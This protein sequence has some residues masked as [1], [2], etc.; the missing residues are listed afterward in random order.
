MIIQFLPEDDL[1][2]LKSNLTALEK[3]FANPTNDWLADVFGGK[4]PF[5]DTKFKVEDFELDMSQE[6][7]F[8]S[9]FENVKRVYNRLRF[10]TDS[11]ASDERLW[12]ALCLGPFY[13][14]T[15]YRWGIK[16]NCKASEIEQHFLFASGSRRGVTRN[17]VARLWWI[18]RLTYNEK[19][20]YEL[21]E[22]LCSN[23]DF[24]IQVL[25]RNTSN[26]PTILRAFLRAI[27]DAKKEGCQITQ[28]RVR[29]LAK[30][31]NLLGGTYILDCLT[32][33]Q[34]YN[35][36]YSKAITL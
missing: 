33:E 3:N 24:V 8:H 36:I 25:E 20:E 30:Y 21:T 14:Y 29:D 7:P 2:R 18:G 32:Y 35:K 26:N 5:K 34:I 9:E 1:L 23:A 27:I 16:E 31:L 4:M 28:L 22:F 10:L 13:K 11:Q 19:D 6:N 17:A 15:K 12:A